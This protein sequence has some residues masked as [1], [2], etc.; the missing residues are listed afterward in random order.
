MLLTQ[1]QKADRR[2][3]TAA[4]DMQTP[5][6]RRLS[7]LQHFTSLFN[8]KTLLVILLLPAVATP[9][10][11]PSSLSSRS[12]GL[13]AALHSSIPEQ[14]AT[15]HQ[16]SEWAPITVHYWVVLELSGE[17]LS[18]AN[19]PLHICGS[20]GVQHLQSSHVAVG[21]CTEFVD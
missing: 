2:Y 9:R 4:A 21:H 13:L 20:W 18:I 16:T 8:I 11:I 6:L 19:Q 5:G 3:Q 12:V 7:K 14:S 1:H 17:L 15:A 10:S